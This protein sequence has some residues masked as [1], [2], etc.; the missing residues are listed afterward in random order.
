MNPK[1]REIAK[2][3]FGDM[4]RI[5]I[6]EPLDVI[7]FHNFMKKAFIILTDSGGIQ[8]EAP[9]LGIPVLVLRDVTERP[10]GVD[11]GTLKIIGC[12]EIK[13]YENTKLLIENNAEY[14]KMSH[15]N[16][17]YGDGNAAKIIVSIIEKD[18]FADYS[19]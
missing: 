16:N 5:K 2:N 11:A 10:E 13:I 8:E 17:P 7:E 12:N 19:I 4:D 9:S 6:I 14:T 3:V 1:I 18:I 15:A